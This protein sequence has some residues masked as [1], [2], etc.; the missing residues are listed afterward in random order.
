M[1]STEFDRDLMEVL[2]GIPIQSLSSGF[3]ELFGAEIYFIDPIFSPSDDEGGIDFR[4]KSGE[5]CDELLQ[6]RYC[7]DGENS[8]SGQNPIYISSNSQPVQVKIS[9]IIDQMLGSSLGEVS[10][11]DFSIINDEDLAAAMSITEVE[12]SANSDWLQDL[13]PIGFP[14]TNINLDLLLSLIHISEP[15]R[16][17]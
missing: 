9:R 13:L 12:F 7:L 10:S 14:N 4:H 6:V 16:P 11:L 15:T 5:T 8:M 3:S 1:V 17:Y 2:N